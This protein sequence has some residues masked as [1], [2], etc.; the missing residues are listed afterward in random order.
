M[1]G[2]NYGPV[3]INCL[4]AG[5]DGGS[6]PGHWG[7]GHQQRGLPQAGCHFQHSFII[8]IYVALLI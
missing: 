2:V 8:L 4:V 5:C 6:L 3:V 7:S 1:S